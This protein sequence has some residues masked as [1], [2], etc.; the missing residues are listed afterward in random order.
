MAA[1]GD[2]RVLGR[3]R[4]EIFRRPRKIFENLDKFWKFSRNF[5]EF[6][7]IL[8]FFKDF[9][10][11]PSCRTFK[12][13]WNSLENNDFIDLLGFGPAEWTARASGLLGFLNLGYSKSS[14][15]RGKSSNTIFFVVFGWS[16]AGP[17]GIS[18]VENDHI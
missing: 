11:R 8:V 18:V 6:W 17:D 4:A 3:V 12:T 9:E 5:E 13:Y 14:F 2:F 15:E 1:L 16:Q 7:E 10:A